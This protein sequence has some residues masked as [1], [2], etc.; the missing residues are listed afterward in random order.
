MIVC[1]HRRLRG[2][3]EESMPTHRIT[4]I[5]KAEDEGSRKKPFQVIS[6]GR[7]G[8]IQKVSQVL[9]NGPFYEISL[10]SEDDP[11]EILTS[12]LQP[13][14]GGVFVLKMTA[15]DHIIFK[16]RKFKD[17]CSSRV[18]RKTRRRRKKK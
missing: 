17:A 14:E 6:E 1:W 4:F 8:K 12:L 5:Y 10:F 7:F 9:E 3:K 11:E 13:S 15:D 18:P 2:R 16:H